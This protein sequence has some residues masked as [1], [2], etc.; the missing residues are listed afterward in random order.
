MAKKNTKYSKL[1]IKKKSE[2]DDNVLVPSLQDNNEK[3]MEKK[4][5]LKKIGVKTSDIQN[6]YTAEDYIRQ[7]NDQLLHWNKYNKTTLKKFCNEKN[8]KIRNIAIRNYVNYFKKST[9]EMSIHMAQFL[10]Y[11]DRRSVDVIIAYPDQVCF[12]IDPIPKQRQNGSKFKIKKVHLMESMIT[13]YSEYTVIDK[14]DSFDENLQIFYMNDKYRLYGAY[15]CLVNKKNYYIKFGYSERENKEIAHEYWN[16]KKLKNK[17]CSIVCD[18]CHLLK[19]S[20]ASVAVLTLDCGLTLQELVNEKKINEKQAKEKV[21]LVKSILD[22]FNFKHGDL[23]KSFILDNYVCTE[24][25][26]FLLTL[27]S[28]F[29]FS[30]LF[31][32]LQKNKVVLLKLFI[33]AFF[34]FQLFVHQIFYSKSLKSIFFIYN[35]IKFFLYYLRKPILNIQEYIIFEIIK[36]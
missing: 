5:Q 19:F 26:F 29:L 16:C 11:M 21:E 15:K 33:R 13:S 10:I 30:T 2:C 34:L 25:Y 27:I 23:E 32:T 7:H 6:T 14:T 4:I 36:I 12:D 8:I 9:P 28:F 35:I 20:N 22:K 24:I 17:S 31:L 3:I 1:M 18:D